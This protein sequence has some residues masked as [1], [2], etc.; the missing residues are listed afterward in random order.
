MIFLLV[1]SWP[2]VGFVVASC[3]RVTWVLCGC[4][5][6]SFRVSIW[7]IALLYATPEH[8]EFGPHRDTSNLATPVHFVF[9]V[10]SWLGRGIS[11]VRFFHNGI[12]AV[13]WFSSWFGVGHLSGLKLQLVLALHRSCVAVAFSPFEFPFGL[14]PCCICWSSLSSSGFCF[15]LTLPGHRNAYFEITSFSYTVCGVQ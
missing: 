8:L 5:V 2:L 3:S 6:F 12:H 13:D 15:S 11:G 10:A 9:H 7:F 4:C 14:L 1:G